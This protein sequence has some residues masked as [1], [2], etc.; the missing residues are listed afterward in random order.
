MDTIK[1]K[2]NI[3]PDDVLEE[4]KKYLYENPPTFLN[5]Y[6]VIYFGYINRCNNKQLVSICNKNKIKKSRRGVTNSYVKRLNILTSYL[7]KDIKYKFLHRKKEEI[8]HYV[9]FS[10]GLHGI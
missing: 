4:I 3:L 9:S 6:D 7:N 5:L 2:L 8:E 1:K 10:R